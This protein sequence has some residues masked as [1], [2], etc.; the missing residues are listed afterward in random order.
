MQASPISIPELAGAA[1]FCVLIL[2]KTFTFVAKMRNGKP[3]YT[4]G[5]AGDKTT[6]FWK[7]EFRNGVRE[8]LA[9][10]GWGETLKEIAA[11]V[12]KLVVLEEMRQRER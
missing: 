11:S 5:N 7:S 12:N 2:D 4:N 10:Q 6:D 9:Q 1:A 8:V 3:G